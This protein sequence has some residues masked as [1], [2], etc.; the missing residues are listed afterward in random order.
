MYLLTIIFIDVL[1]SI[2]SKWMMYA[3]N[4]DVANNLFSTY[5][6]TTST[7]TLFFSIKIHNVKKLVILIN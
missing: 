6:N 7:Y 5:V 3:I 2:Q 4:S 1:D